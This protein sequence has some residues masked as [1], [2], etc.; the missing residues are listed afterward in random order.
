MDRI[1]GVNVIKKADHPT[2]IRAEDHVIK[3][4]IPK[5]RG[6]AEMRPISYGQEI[7][8]GNLRQLPFVA[9]E[10]FAQILLNA[11]FVLLRAST[12]LNIPYLTHH[13]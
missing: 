11:Q 4:I 1:I 12:H 9:S 5:N 7:I 3:E 6:R 2:V 8:L 10:I 13:K